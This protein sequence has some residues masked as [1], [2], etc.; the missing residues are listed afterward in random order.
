MKSVIVISVILAAALGTAR[1]SFASDFLQTMQT[2]KES[3][4]SIF[5]N[6]PKVSHGHRRTALVRP[7]C[8]HDV[9]KLLRSFDEWKEYPPCSKEH[10]AAPPDLIIFY[11]QTLL[12][13]P[14]HEK[15]LDFVR[16]AQAMPWRSCFDRIILDNAGLA[17]EEDIYAPAEEKTNPKWNQGPNLQFFSI[18]KKLSEAKYEYFYLNEPDTVPLHSNWLDT[19]TD[20]VDRQRPFVVLGSSYSGSKWSAFEDE[21]PQPLVHHINGNAF[22]NVSSAKLMSL[23]LEMEKEG[24]GHSS[25]DLRLAEKLIDEH[26][27]LSLSNHGYIDTP[28]L[29]NHAASIV[30]KSEISTEV[31][32]IHGAKFFERFPENEG[33]HLVVSD[34]DNAN[35][36][37]ATLQSFRDVGSHPFSAAKLM[38]YGKENAKRASD[39]ESD[40]AGVARMYASADYDMCDAQIRTSPWLMLTNSMH[41]IDEEFALPVQRIGEVVK[42]VMFY[43]P[44]SSDICDE[45]CRARAVRGIEV[46]PMR[47]AFS[48][49]ILAEYCDATLSKGAKPSASGYAAFASSHHAET[50]VWLDISKY[51]FMNNFKSVSASPKRVLSMNSRFL[52][53]MNET[54]CGKLKYF[55]C[56]RNVECAWKGRP[57]KTC[58]VR[59]CTERL[60]ETTCNF[61]KYCSWTGT[62]CERKTKKPTPSPTQK[63]TK[64]P[65]QFPTKRPTKAPT[66]SPTRPPTLP[67]CAG[68]SDYL[69]C[70]R[71]DCFWDRRDKTCAENT[72]ASR[73]GKYCTVHNWYKAGMGCKLQDGT[74]VDAVCSDVKIYLNCKV[75]GPCSWNA[76]KKQCEDRTAAPTP[77]PTPSTFKC[78]DETN[79]RV[80]TNDKRCWWSGRKTGC[81]PNTCGFFSKSKCHRAPGCTFENS[82][83]R[84]AICSDFNRNKWTCS[85][86]S[87]GLH[88][89]YNEDKTCSPFVSP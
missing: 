9:N 79:W 70:V 81:V 19:L 49:K 86:E 35:G 4:V 60:T 29:E 6:Q 63:P 17:P 55:K 58:Y 84:K 11:S 36:N 52:T 88:C 32:M 46:H 38:L 7:F 37:E 28:L 5:Q 67:G 74:C 42:P 22:Y 25:F 85:G 41:V 18:V 83:C 3:V 53:S 14:H 13:S 23:V 47:V 69:S 76:K 20:E 48:T 33:I 66:Q 39:P 21:L 68:K 1:A 43:T 75:K 82:A 77:G 8:P 54:S 16:Q 26:G 71:S 87:H 34:W 50:Y 15:L 59:E 57:H 24:A 27:V 12:S 61:G 78:T 72:C 62:E 10:T 51:G 80:C 73:Y 44:S 45:A 65:T 30:I 2:A 64:S 40:I 89:I 56:R 31:Q